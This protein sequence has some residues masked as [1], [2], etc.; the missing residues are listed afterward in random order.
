MQYII[1]YTFK[2]YLFND[3]AYK[4]NLY[5]EVDDEDIMYINNIINICIL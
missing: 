1:I 4:R 3:D 2:I 5:Y